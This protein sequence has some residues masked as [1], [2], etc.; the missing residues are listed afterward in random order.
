MRIHSRRHESTTARC[1][2]WRSAFTM[3]EIMCVVT[4]MAIA[5]ALVFVGMTSDGYV[6]AKAG[7]RTIVA[8]L[9]MA[10]NTA[11]ATQSSVFVT[12]NATSSTSAGV[13]ADS[14]ALCSAISPTA[15]F[16]TN[17]VTQANYQVNWGSQAWSV[18]GVSFGGATSMEFNTLGAP[19]SSGSTPSAI[20]SASTVTVS[21]GG[22][23][24]TITV[25]PYTGD[26]TV[27]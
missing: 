15:T 21:S 22:Y 20:T 3:I 10:Q 24:V 26:I 12:F 25:Q 11:I 2:R 16:L 7:A 5:A 17:P 14:Y 1:G 13:A 6:N 27:Q 8:D 4:I 9:L 18:S 19:M 23:S